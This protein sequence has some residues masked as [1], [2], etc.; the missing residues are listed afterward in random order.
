MEKSQ[1]EFSLPF[2]S[3][4]NIN[5]MTDNDKQIE[6]LPSFLRRNFNF[7]FSEKNGNVGQN[8]F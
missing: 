5:E 6:N 7:T 2:Y 4:F 1:G 3:P 8:I